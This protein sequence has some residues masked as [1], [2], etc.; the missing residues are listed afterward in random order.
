MVK[1]R[2]Y[3][4]P[5]NQEENTPLVTIL[6]TRLDLNQ[7]TAID[8]RKAPYVIDLA[9]ASFGG[10]MYPKVGSQWLLKKISGVWT[11]MARAPQQNPQL[12]PSFTPQAGDTFIG[13]EGKT[14]VINDLQVN[15]NEQVNGNLNVGGVITPATDAEIG[16]IKIHASNTPPTGWLICD[17]SAVSRTTYAQLFVVVG[18]NFG[19]G[20]GSTTFNLPDLRGKVPVGRDSGQT[21]FDVLGETGGEKTHTLTAQELPDHNHGLPMA[22]GASANNTTD[23]P[24]RGTG[25]GDAS[26]RNR[27][28]SIYTSATYGSVA[29]S[30]SRAHNNLQPYIS[31][32]YIIKGLSNYIPPTALTG[33]TADG[34]HA[35]G[36]SSASEG[37]TARVT[38]DINKRLIIRDSGKMEWGDGT[39]VQDT[40]FER[41]GAGYIVTNATVQSTKAVV[42]NVAYAANV[43]GD[44]QSRFNVFNGGTLQ[45]GSGS[46]GQDT[47]LY[48]GAAGV[49]KTDSD[50]NYGGQSVGRGLLG[51]YYAV[52]TT[53]SPGST[54]SE[55]AITS[56]SYTA[57]PTLAL[58]NGRVFRFMLQF[59]AYGSSAVAS[60]TV[61]RVRAGAQTISGTQLGYYDVNIGPFG[62]IVAAYSYIGF[63]KNTSGSTVNTK[64]SITNIRTTGA[65][66]TFLYG[67]ANI[68]ILMTVEDIGSSSDPNFASLVANIA[69]VP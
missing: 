21:E 34:F 46:A 12:A 6:E 32:N 45:W 8:S 50:F 66:T 55:I 65:T 26:F 10:I 18:V 61:V 22:I 11:L 63:F 39:N 25:P 69:S 20:D 9:K 67:D 30:G 54:G 27:D 59:G 17:G 64:L 53:F 35:V 23:V 57:E 58:A 2:T 13:G 1:N 38:G 48:R 31:L 40:T 43:T 4:N 29:I 28:T 60:L 33:I 41:T 47:N 42:G 15:G 68:P 5:I 3:H 51:T 62:G 7:S 52:P 24:A 19:V 37:H 16:T 49:L 56:V 14:Y 36:S 44:T